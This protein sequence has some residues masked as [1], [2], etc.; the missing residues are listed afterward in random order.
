MN[1]LEQ[2]LLNTELVYSGSSTYVSKNGII[3]P[4][5]TEILSKMMHDDRLMYWANS[6]GFKGIRYKEALNKAANLGTAAHSA[7][8]LFL[9]QKIKTEDNIPFLGFLSWYDIVSD[10]HSINPI[11]IE[12][13]LVCDLFGGT[14]DALLDIGGNL[15]L[16][17]FKTSNHVRMSY[18]LQLAAYRYMLKKTENIDID[19]IVVLQLDKDTPGF[20]EY[21]LNF[22]NYEHKAFI[23]HCELTFLS[24]VYAFYNV[25][26]SDNIFNILF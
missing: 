24:L 11:Y 18:F 20:N 22:K 13:S 6:L 23:D 26:K 15:Y 1:N 5:V 19:G 3:V 7:I 9:K 2:I 14:L 12:H 4:R 8:E 17:D 25:Q 21:I 16:I 10:T